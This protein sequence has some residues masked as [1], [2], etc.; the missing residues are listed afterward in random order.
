[1]IAEEGGFYRTILSYLSKK[2]KKE[3][4][5]PVL[6]VV[7]QTYAS[8]SGVSYEEYYK[9]PELMLRTQIKFFEEFKDTFTLPGIWPD[10]GLIPEAGALGCEVKFFSY[11]DPQIL[12]PAL[13]L[14]DV[15]KLRVPDPSE[16]EYTRIV[17][18][19]LRYFKYNLPS[20]VQEKFE[21]LDGHVFCGG[22]GEVSALVVGYDQ[23]LIG[24]YDFPQK[25]HILIRKV[26]NFIKD[27]IEAQ[28]EIVG[29][30]KRVIIWDH[31]P[32]M[33]SFNLYREFIH[34]YLKEIFLTYNQAEV[35]VYHNENNYTHLLPLIKELKANI[36]HIGP[37]QDLNKSSEILKGCI[38]GNIHPIKVLLRSTPDHIKK[39]CR[40]KVSNFKGKCLLLSTG[41]GMAPKTPL[42]NIRALVNWNK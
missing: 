7:G 39:I 24:M 23:F 10:L 18:K 4:I 35:R 5:I 25:V 17:L 28:L 8:L 29:P 19:Y 22:P 31:S 3:R 30:P 32:G 9:N 16:A 40:E 41:G 26:T 12:R 42:E 13:S 14:Q 27:Y 11:Q 2:K 37:D 15:N 6:W 1:M 36:Y 38:M 21:F 34:P 20:S 33:C